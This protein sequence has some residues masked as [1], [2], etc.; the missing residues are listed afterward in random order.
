[1]P[2]S[3]DMPVSTTDPASAGDPSPEPERR[4]T[5]AETRV[6]RSRELEEIA[7][8]IAGRIRHVCANLPEDEFEQLAL[9]MARMKL[10]F[11]DLD[12]RFGV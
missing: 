2:F 7:A 6:L 9:D 12:R 3:S 11:R 4:Y 10:R 1:M 8:D 5:S